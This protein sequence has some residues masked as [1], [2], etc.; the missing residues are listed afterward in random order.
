MLQNT[1]DKNNIKNY[2]MP[3]REPLNLKF[4]KED[5]MSIKVLTIELESNMVDNAELVLNEIGLDISTYIRIA[6]LKLVK[7]QRVPFNLSA[8][9]PVNESMPALPKVIPVVNPTDDEPVEVEYKKS[10]PRQMGKITSDMCQS[11]WQEFKT[12]FTS[13]DMSLLESAQRIS[14]QTGMNKGSAFIYFII[15]SNLVN[16]A[17][18]TRSLKM[19]DLEF[20][21]GKIKEELPAQM[22]KA[23]IASLE[24]SIPY[25][26]DK[27]P[28]SFAERVTKL[29][30]KLKRF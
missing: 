1:I 18:N 5:I 17:Q 7:E 27:V 21:I 25:W 20:F 16:G 4:A 11:I 12:H 15:L 8:S 9:Q 30:E 14:N 2:T 28:G 26:N 19:E 6:L 3:I 13:R 10:E 29:V 24:A 22:F 23:A